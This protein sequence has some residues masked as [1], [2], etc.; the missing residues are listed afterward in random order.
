MSLYAPDEAATSSKV[1]GERRVL[2]DLTGVF[3]D[4]WGGMQEHVLTLGG[5]LRELGWTPILLA[6]TR[7]ADIYEQRL[8]AEGIR[9]LGVPALQARGISWQPT[10]PYVQALYQTLVHERIA[11]YH[12]HSALMGHELQS[13]TAARLARVPVVMTYH[14][15]PWNE[16]RQ[17]R[18]AMMAGHR[19]FR[20][21]V[22]AVSSAVADMATTNYMV[23]QGDTATILNG[24]RDLASGETAGERP[25]DD[26]EAAPRPQ[27]ADEVVLGVAA[28][29]ERVK[30][31][32][33]L[34]E[35]LALIDP[36]TPFRVI[37]AGEGPE[38]RG[39]EEQARRLHLEHKVAFVGFKPDIRQAM[40]QWD[41]VVLPSR[42]QEGLPLTAIE[43]LAAQRPLIA[44]RVGGLPEIVRDGENG[45]LVP[46]ED[47]RALA[48]AL[49]DAI[50]NRLERLRRGSRSREIFLS[51]LQ[52]D[53]MAERTA[54]IYRTMLG[55]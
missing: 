48:N 32:D 40:L 49:L 14:C 43:A 28:R 25:A 45:W 50:Q 55:T 15:T 38:R 27:R 26:V 34:L 4:K 18:L 19:V 21:R 30:G 44:S 36:A 47:A 29:L 12:I 35:A 37:I 6:H 10:V 17:R 53:V 39:L 5:E 8:L 52:A 13:L 1:T 51:E 54:A 46:P 11:V 33:V 9:V 22:I 24:V 2:F 23:P 7:Y 42:S 41:I 3:D 16:S 20:P 31:L